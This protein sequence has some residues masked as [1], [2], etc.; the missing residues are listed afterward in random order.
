MNVH[1]AKSQLSKLLDAAARGED[2]FVSRRGKLFQIVPAPVVD[3]AALFGALK[4]QIRYSADY[5]LADSETEADFE[6]S[7]DKEW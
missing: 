1:E 2:V 5:D 4:G 6:A 7:L 3:R